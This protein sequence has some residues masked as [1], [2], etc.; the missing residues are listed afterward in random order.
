[1]RIVVALGGNALLRRGEP[2]DIAAQ[3]RNAATAARA[4][5]QIAPGNEIVVTHG[6]GPQ[7]GFLALQAASDGDSPVPLD[8]LGAESEGMIGYL[9]ARALIEALP[10]TPILSV[11]TQVEVDP[12]DPAFSRPTKPIGP[13]YPPDEWRRIAP[14]RGWTGIEDRGQIR[15]VVASPPPR[16]I[17]E[18]EA[19]AR[20]V[21]SGVT[22][23][24]AGGGGIPAARD[25]AGRLTGVEAV[26]DKDRT[27]TL[28]ATGLGADALMLL[29][30]VDAVYSNWGHPA[31]TAL[32]R[33]DRAAAATLALAPGSM[34]P[35]VEAGFAFV[36]ATGG[37]AVIAALDCAVAALAGKSGTELIANRRTPAPSP[38]P[39]P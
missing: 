33:L 8:V 18:R 17:V 10:G 25:A 28:L 35:K 2:A 23:I 19:I 1:M 7:I 5:A 3:S 13:F 21:R 29:T 27:A 26:V 24:C 14:A 34:G 32:R 11:L 38:R 36:E 22:A 16:A 30:D 6:N 4:I 12:A 9:L 37:R 15:R 39:V 31:A 20:L